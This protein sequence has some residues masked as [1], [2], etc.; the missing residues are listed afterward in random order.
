MNFSADGTNFL[1]ITFADL[2]NKIFSFILERLTKFYNQIEF[3]S[4]A[5]QQNVSHVSCSDI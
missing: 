1:D 3:T 2:F 5:V 4:Q